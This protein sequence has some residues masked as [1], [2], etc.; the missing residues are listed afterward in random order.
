MGHAS[1]QS[2]VRSTASRS[3]APNRSVAG[4]CLT[5]AVVRAIVGLH[6]TDPT[7]LDVR[8][9]D[10]VNPDALNALF[11]WGDRTNDGRETAVVC[12]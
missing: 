6:D 8:L 10:Y 12:A 3:A 11:E 1:I 5:A 4:H 9:A 2:T 7:E